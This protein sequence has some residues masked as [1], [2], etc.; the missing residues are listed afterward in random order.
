MSAKVSLTF[1]II[2]LSDKKLVNRDK[3]LPVIPN[4]LSL[5]MSLGIDKLL[6]ACAKST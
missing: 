5:H 4:V 1:T 2:F 6:N 3:Q